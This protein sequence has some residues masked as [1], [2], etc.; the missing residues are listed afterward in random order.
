MAGQGGGNCWLLHRGTEEGWGRI[1]VIRGTTETSDCFLAS[2][3]QREGDTFKKRGG[4]VL[5]DYK[6]RCAARFSEN[7]RYETTTYLASCWKGGGKQKWEEGPTGNEQW[8]EGRLYLAQA[9]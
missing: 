5:T 6:G 9:P 2:R 3:L 7:H 4:S 1:C 8:G